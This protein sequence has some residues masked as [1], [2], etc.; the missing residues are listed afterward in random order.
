LRGAQ[1]RLNGSAPQDVKN[2][3]ATKKKLENP[4]KPQASTQLGKKE[5]TVNLGGCETESLGADLRVSQKKQ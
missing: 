1:L 4:K 2:T 5:N 3:P